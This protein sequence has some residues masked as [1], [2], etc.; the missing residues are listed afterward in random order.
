V[1][2]CE[3][4]IDN[5]PCSRLLRGDKARFL[6]QRAFFRRNIMFTLANVPQA[7][8]TGPIFGL[9]L[10][11]IGNDVPC[12]W[13]VLPELDGL[14]KQFSVHGRDIAHR[15]ICQTSG[16]AGCLM[17]VARAS[18][19]LPLC[20]LGKHLRIALNPEPRQFLRFFDFE[21]ETIETRSV[22]RAAALAAQ[23]ARCESAR[24]ALG[25][26]TPAACCR[27]T[28]SGSIP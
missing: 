23:P 16:A 26:G 4:V 10:F 28:R 5:A 18:D 20:L 6:R 22:R 3:S 11:W 1:D 14:V 7:A 2:Y 21:A 12:S 27:A 24:R 13:Y 9:A 15:G 25:R 19:G 8:D 17:P